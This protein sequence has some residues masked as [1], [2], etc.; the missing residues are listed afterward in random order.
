[1]EQS[2]GVGVKMAYERKEK[3]PHVWE[4][5]ED[6][7][8]VGEIRQV[9]E[10]LFQAVLENGSVLPDFYP[11]FEVAEYEIQTYLAWKTYEEERKKNAAK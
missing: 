4:C 5:I 2:F 1:M 3:A 7:K 8:V 6:G 10:S 9:G 11:S